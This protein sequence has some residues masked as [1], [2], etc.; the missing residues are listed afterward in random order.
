MRTRGLL[1]PLIFA[2]LAGCAAPDGRR[3]VV[4][5]DR[6]PKAIGPYSQAIRAGNTLYVAGQIALDPATGEMVAGGIRTQTHQV[7]KNIGAILDAAGF[8]F[9]DVVQCQVFLTDL[10]NYSD[11]N[12]VYAE[13]FRT[14][15]PARAVIQVSRIPR[16]GLLEIMVVAVKSPRR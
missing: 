14:D 7:L 16:D 5:T 1:Y 15:P 8:S 12:Q 2:M 10:G 9:N 4:S 6:A 11:V 13:Y 3:Q